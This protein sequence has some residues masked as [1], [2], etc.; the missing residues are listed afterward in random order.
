[1]NHPE[2]DPY[3]SWTKRKESLGGEGSLSPLEVGLFFFLS[4]LY[5]TLI[6]TGFL[7]HSGRTYLRAPPVPRTL[8]LAALPSDIHRPN[9]TIT[10]CIQV[11]RRH[12]N[13]CRP[14]ALPAIWPHTIISTLTKIKT[15]PHRSTRNRTSKTLRGKSVPRRL[16]RLVGGRLITLPVP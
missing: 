3:K 15:S 2:C 16:F 7:S 14:K 8:A 4:P 6:L 12:M 9:K 5:L 11:R 13:G 10:R 1:M